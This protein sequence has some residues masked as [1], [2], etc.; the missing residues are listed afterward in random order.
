MSEHK[1]DLELCKFMR[2][3]IKDENFHAELEWLLFTG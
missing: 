3:G 2:K 1:L